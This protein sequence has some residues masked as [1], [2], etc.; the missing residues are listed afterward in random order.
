M[1]SD[2]PA[3][4]TRRS[5]A[6]S[7]AGGGGGLAAWIPRDLGEAV[8]RV[9]EYGSKAIGRAVDG[10]DAEVRSGR[11]LS[12]PRTTSPAEPASQTA[13]AEASAGDHGV[14]GT[15]MHTSH[16]Q[17]ALQGVGLT[18]E[19][20]IACL[21]FGSADSALRSFSEQQPPA[22]GFSEAGFAAASVSGEPGG[23]TRQPAG[24]MTSDP[25]LAV[26]P[27]R[28]YSRPMTV[29]EAAQ[30]RA[31][32][33][34][35]DSTDSSCLSACLT[36]ASAGHEHCQVKD[37]RSAAH[38]QLIMLCARPPPSADMPSLKWRFLRTSF[39]RPPRVVKRCK[40]AD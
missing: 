38:L 28:T 27:A 7:A 16:S 30:R 4:K 2:H 19:P 11:G 39:E 40:S 9:A 3:Q 25:V 32:A 14:A 31:V 34:R 13:A 35:L 29:L 37:S 21:T 33:V 23:Q 5:P 26:P 15:S 12:Q 18:P 10:P 1:R 20:G 8:R 6:G 24:L 22:A 36:R 17:Q